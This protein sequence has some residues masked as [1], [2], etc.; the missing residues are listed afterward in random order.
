[1]L[2]P[3]T[4]SASLGTQACVN[5]TISDQNNKPLAGV[6]VD[7]NVS[8]VNPTSGF[9]FTANSGVA[10]FCYTGTNGGIDTITAS[11][12]TLADTATVSIT[13]N[14][15]T[16]P[17]ITWA[18]PAAITYGTALSAVQLNA[19]ASVPGSFVYTPAA[20][21]VPAAGARTLS[22]T[23]TPTDTAAYTTAT[24]TV[25]LTVTKASATV[26]LGSLNQ[27]YDG[28]PRAATATTTPAGLG[29]T[30]SY[31]DS[32]VVPTTAGNHTVV[33]TVSDVNYQGSASGTLVIAKAT[34][35]ITWAN[36]APINAGTPLSAAQ[37][38]A[39]ASVPGTFV[40]TP[41]AGAILP[42]GTQ[43]LSA[44]FTPTDTVNYN[45]AT[46]TV[47]ITVN[48]KITP[49]ITWA[50]PAAI[51]YGT[52]LSAVQLNATASV[53]GTFVYTPAAGTVPAAGARTLSVTFTPSD[54]AAYNTATATV[55][56][57]VTKASA[58]VTLGSLNQTY[59]G[60]PRAATATTTPA[61]LSVTFSYDDSSVVPTTA[62]NHTVVATVSDVNY[63][64]STS[65]T[66]VIARA[67]PTITWASPAPITV[68]TALSAVQLNATASVP[69]TFV[70]T[71]A[72]GAILPAGTQTLST[73]F[74][75]TDTANYSTATATVSIT[76]RVV[77]TPKITPTITWASPAAIT[78]GM[79]LSATQL[80]ATTTV[81]GSFVYTPAAGTVLAAGARTLSVTFTPTDTATYTTATATVPLPVNKAS[82]AVTL[83]S[84][85]QTFDGTPRAATATTTPAGLSVTFTYGGSPVAPTT[86]GSYAVVATVSDVNY[87]GSASG[88]LVVA[89]L[90]DVVIM[91]NSSG[92]GSTSPPG[93][94]VTVP[95]GGSPTITFTPVFGYHV[96][97]I[98]VDGALQPITDPRLATVTFPN[99]LT[100]HVVSVSFA[101]PDGRAAFNN[102]VAA[103]SIADA[104]VA[105]QIAVGNMSATPDHLLHGDVAPLGNG[106]P[107]PDGKIDIGDVVVI[108]RKVLGLVAW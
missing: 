6:R 99:A 41:A 94:V 11:V 36:P 5:A 37:L 75:A 19:T 4:V 78:Y 51:T 106:R 105:M 103:I 39:A 100:N 10:Q 44:T 22:V 72:A 25:P 84:L 34:P 68:G 82:A 23:F 43:T 61:G 32:S 83:G 1:V 58:T 69:G 77:D 33:A 48:P 47:S 57:T 96:Q 66:L 88:T 20:G 64:G 49:T 3:K 80:N 45:T 40:Y 74:T 89:A 46:A 17:T 93:P 9:Q 59:D 98:K 8:G 35:I 79:A 54:T 15:K 2:S 87:Q 12:G 63:Q 27:T 101:P 26:T 102:G 108:M 18:S 81:P 67:T 14:P 104:V 95:A 28:T 65:G 60:T 73:T 53:P 52:A 90:P 97:E 50:N 29:V 56:L 71:P 24:A 13:V 107:A 92:D 31:D 70:Y 85:N 7:F 62:G 55:P 16:D 76:V 86:A 30:F 38:N 21:T 42:V 91:V